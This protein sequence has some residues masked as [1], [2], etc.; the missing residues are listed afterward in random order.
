MRLTILKQ[1]LRR[2]RRVLDMAAINTNSLPE[3]RNP[4]TWQSIN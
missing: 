3:A 4:G 2:E 1:E